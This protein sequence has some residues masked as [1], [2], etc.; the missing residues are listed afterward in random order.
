MLLNIQGYEVA[1][2]RLGS[3]PYVSE[4]LRAQY[5]RNWIFFKELF[6]CANSCG[7]SIGGKLGK[8]YLELQERERN[9]MSTKELTNLP[10]AKLMGQ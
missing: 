7:D 5:G 4:T 3:I 1:A 9:I 10:N 2:L 8:H 6:S